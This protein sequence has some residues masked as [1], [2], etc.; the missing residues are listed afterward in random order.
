VLADGWQ[1]QFQAFGM[2]VA[3]FTALAGLLAG[4]E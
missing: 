1:S 3:D 4:G 2:F